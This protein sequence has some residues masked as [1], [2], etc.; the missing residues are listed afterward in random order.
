MIPSTHANV[1][2][3]LGVESAYDAFIDRS[4]CI[5]FIHFPFGWLYAHRTIADETMIYSPFIHSF[6]NN[7]FRNMLRNT[8][9]TLR[10]DQHHGTSGFTFKTK[11]L[12]EIITLNQ[13]SWFFPFSDLILY[14]IVWYVQN[15]A[16][17]L[18]FATVQLTE[19]NE[20]V[21]KIF[22]Q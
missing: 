1:M 2:H 8:E 4:K 22:E 13:F 19:R 9:N 5:A 15:L 11:A 10:H 20:N 17:S 6:I 21:Y 16:V 14:N 12:N 7:A 3:N 18:Q